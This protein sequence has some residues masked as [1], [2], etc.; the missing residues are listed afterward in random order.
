MSQLQFGVNV[1][2]VSTGQDL[3]D[4]VRRAEDLGYD[5][6]AAPD[7]LAAL[8]PFSALSAAAG[9]SEWLRLRTYV[10][11]IGFWNPALLAR[12]VA[13]LDVISGGRAELGVGAGHMK[14][15][16]DDAGLAWRPLAERTEV[17]ERSLV[18][19]RERLADP[20]HRPRPVQDRVPVLVG[21]MS[22]PG[23]AV[24]ARQA[25]IVALSGL[26]QVDG[27]PI[28]TFTMCHAA[29][30]HHRAS[31][32]RETAGDREYSGD[33]LLQFVVVDE[34]PADAAA[35]IVGEVGNMSVDR[36]L[37]SPFA[38][39]ARDADEAAEQLHRRQEAYGLDSVVTH[40]PNLEALG[41]VL[42]AY[43]G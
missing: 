23:L 1:H 19:V 3:G 10:L 35:R 5:V 21:A 11:N 4:L 25:D 41:E 30:T 22:G 37:D 20:A 33:L 29:E 12:E 17:L 27:A 9:V 15:E 24:A 26:R 28:G 36:L 13:T 32:V 2:G 8:A 31:Q 34:D 6:L 43:R 18:E 42:R 14:S 7:H 39:L 38:L 16:Y 40:Q